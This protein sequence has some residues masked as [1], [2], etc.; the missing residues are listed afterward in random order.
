MKAE[1][2]MNLLR[3]RY[4]SGAAI[5]LIGF[6]AGCSGGRGGGGGGAGTTGRG[7]EVVTTETTEYRPPEQKQDDLLAD[8]RLDQKTNSFDPNLV[9]RRPLGE[10]LVNQSAA[11]LRLDVPLV[12]PDTEAPLLTIFPSYAAA[13][14][15]ARGKVGFGDGILASVNMIDGKAKQ[16]DDGLY[17]AIDQA[18]YRGLDERLRGHV[19]LVLRI[20]ERAGPDGPAA[21]FLAAGLKVIGRNVPVTD[22]AARDLWIQRFQQNPVAVKPISFYTWNETLKECWRFLKFFQIELKGRDLAVATQIIE[23][24]QTEPALL[25]EY[26]NVTNLYARLTNPHSCFSLADVL[27]VSPL[28]DMKLKELS[29]ERGVDRAAIA[30]FP[31]S[32]SRETVL[33]EKLFGSGLPENVD[34]MRELIR[35]IRSGEVDLSPKETSG[36]YEY[37]VYALQTLL[38]PEKGDEH[39]KLLLTK[40]YKERMLE[41]FKALITKRR[42]TH[43]RQLAMAEAPTAAVHVER[44]VFV[45]PRLRL[46]PCPT[47]Y[48]RTARAYAFLENLLHA[49]IGPDVLGSIH[50]LR[51]E[52]DRPDD[53]ATELQTMRQ[54]FYGL[55][56]VSAEDIGMKSA[57]HEGELESES[58]CYERASEW[59]MKVLDDPDLAV[60]ARVS[61]PIFVD[62]NRNVTR[63]WVTLGVRLTKLNASYAT[64]PRIKLSEGEGVWQ[65]VENHRLVPADHLIAVDEFA[66]IELH[67]A[68][69]LSRE[70]LRA[71]CDQ[72]KTKEAIIE[73]IRRR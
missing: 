72:A 62:F 14:A 17:A 44:P 50:G 2:R 46:E 67:G 49:A 54:L 48:L 26:K 5:A 52:G 30:M 19:D 6:I 28:D 57:L 12:R 33:F 8:D 37:Q 9:D 32:T 22:A 31:P 55:Y 64:A 36:W 25:E 56:L 60:D 47:Y 68:V 13:V 20:F 18:Y 23:A 16:F 59:L 10:W 1:A 11:V 70:E 51:K 65:D 4:V 45:K 71:I 42:E 3:L 40:A 61:V 53:L 66:E 34:L 63:L 43:A 29:K 69:S 73:A 24:L 7:S 35:R 38:L 15:G 41:A 39:N 58:A 27:E 21:A